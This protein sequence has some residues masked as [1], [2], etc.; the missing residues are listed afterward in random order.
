MPRPAPVI[1]TL[2][3]LMVVKGSVLH[4]R[5]E[6]PVVTH[7]FRAIL[8]EHHVVAGGPCPAGLVGRRPHLAARDVAQEDVA[9]PIVARRVNMTSL[10]FPLQRVS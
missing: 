3:S 4:G 7:E 2:L 6:G 8:G 1:K 10:S 5:G 9:A